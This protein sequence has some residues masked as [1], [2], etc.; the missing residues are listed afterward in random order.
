MDKQSNPEVIEEFR[1]RKGRQLMVLLPVFA[2][3][4]LMA[5]T[6]GP[7]EA[8][9]GISGD[10]LVPISIGVIFAGVAFSIYN[11]RCPSCNGYLGKGFSPKFCTKCGE[12]LQ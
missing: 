2:A 5:M 7:G 3:V 12:Q 1:K 6:D 8:V 11:W 9:M 10:I 4:F